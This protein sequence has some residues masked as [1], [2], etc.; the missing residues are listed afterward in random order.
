MKNLKRILAVIG[1]ILLVALYGST[2]LFAFIDR[3]KTLG[4]F[5]ASIAATILV[6]VL[7]Y[8]YS[9]VYKLSKK[10]KSDTDE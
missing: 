1:V 6:P 10:D 3:T 7:L 2:L 4:F 8:A 9:M 5:K